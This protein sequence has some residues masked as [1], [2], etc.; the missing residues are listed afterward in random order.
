MAVVHVRD[1]ALTQGLTGDRERL[2]ASVDRYRGGGSPEAVLAMLKEVAVSLNASTGRRK[3]VLFIDSGFTLWSPSIDPGAS[4]LDSSAAA[5]AADDRARVSSAGAVE[6]GVAA[7][8]LTRVFEDMTTVA[9]RNNVRIYPISPKGFDA[10]GGLAAARTRAGAAVPSGDRAAQI[11]AQVRILEAGT[12]EDAVA[13]QRI[14][15]ADTGGIAIANTSNY[16]AH[17]A[18]I[19]RDNSAYYL[20]TYESRAD[21]DGHPHSITVRLR[22]RPNLSLE[23]GRL[24]VTAPTPDVK[25]RAVGLPRNLSADARAVLAATTPASSGGIELFTAVYQAADSRGSVLVGTHVPGSMLRLAPNE[26]VELTYLAVDRWG[27]IRAVERRAFTLNLSEQ[28]RAEAGRTGVRLLGRLQVPRG[29]YQIRVAAHQL[30]GITAAASA[31]VEVPDY[32]DQPLTVSEFVVA[33]SHGRRLTTLEE[34]PVLRSALPTQPTPSRRFARGETLAVFAEIYD[35]H[36]V[37]SQEVGVT[38]TVAADD[39]RVAFRREQLLTT[40]NKGRFYFNGTLPLDAFG[41]GDYQLLVEVHTRKGIPANTSRQMRFA[42]VDA[43]A[44]PAPPAL[45]AAGNAEAF[46]LISVRRAPTPKP[47]SPG[48]PLAPG[49][50]RI[51]PDGSFQ[52]RGESLANLARL[53][54]EFENVDP[55]SG[56][57]QAADWMWNDRFD[58]TVSTT[59]PWT[60]PPPGTT[61]P[62]EL[63]TMLRTMLEDRFALRVRVTTKKMN[64]IALRL[65]KRDTP[66][67]ALR[68]AASDVSRGSVTEASDPNIINA[69]AVTMSQ[70]A[71]LLSQHPAYALGG[72]YLDQ[73]GLPGLYDL[74]FSLDSALSG[75]VNWQ[76]RRAEL[77][78]RLGIKLTLTSVQLPALIIE[79]AKKPQED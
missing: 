9:K 35:S 32:A 4:P 59:Q 12:S 1:R 31:N 68:P 73:T 58:V 6:L 77:E 15:A 37:V 39:G 45:R 72:P 38:M 56:R 42:V 75:Q 65:A 19:V 46:E 78:K 62:A 61:V 52:V 66:G 71:L 7:R 16:G 53:A 23:Q 74:T 11:V 34:D 50:L 57:V 8:K 69:K 30:N 60:T 48:A 25:G 36:W 70:V 43:P 26:S 5:R 44:P 14:L 33:S 3:A 29:L 64:V 49:S 22:N 17:F 21:A 18:K 41:P 27:V 13:S 28:N 24:S 79:S 2:L 67:P 10:N 76:I 20:L 55:Q 54:Y 40:A 51:L 47:T 63:R